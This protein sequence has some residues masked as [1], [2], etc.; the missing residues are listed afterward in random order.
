MG[1]ETPQGSTTNKIPLNAGSIG[2]RMLQTLPI[3]VSHLVCPLFQ[4]PI[5]GPRQTRSAVVNFCPLLKVFLLY[6]RGYPEPQGAGRE[7]QESRGDD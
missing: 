2:S 1:D 5:S 7:E 3:A 4:H 6:G